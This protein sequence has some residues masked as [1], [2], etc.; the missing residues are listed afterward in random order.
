MILFSIYLRL[1]TE[2]DNTVVVN[3]KTNL[4]FNPFIEK[5]EEKEDINNC[6]FLLA[7]VNKNFPIYNGDYYVANTYHPKSETSGLIVLQHNQ[8]KPI[9][10]N[11]GFWKILKSNIFSLNIPVFS[12]HELEKFKK[13]VN[14]FGPY[15]G[16]WPSDERQLLEEFKS[17]PPSISKSNYSLN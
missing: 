8:L 17:I 9:P 2:N 3:P 7:I 11:S 13:A 16:K 14:K 10:P 1:K 6:Y 12:Q 4:I 15:P 5:F